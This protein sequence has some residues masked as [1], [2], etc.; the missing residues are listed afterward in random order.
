AGNADR[1]CGRIPDPGLGPR[2][3]IMTT[4][5]LRRF[6]LT[7]CLLAAAQ[8]WGQSELRFSLHTEPKTFH[9]LMVDD[10]ASEAVRYLT[11][12]VLLRLNRRT[13]QLE[14][15][16]ATHWKVSADGH[17]IS[18]TVREGVKFSDGTPFTAAD[19]VYTMKALMDPGLH[20]PLSDTFRSAPGQ[21]KTSLAAHNR[22]T[23][24]FPAT[25]AGL[26]KLFD[27]VAIMSA[28]SPQKERAV[29]GP[30]VVAKYKAGSYVEL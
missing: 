28:K 7:L 9:P 15:E 20:S 27:Q 24:T 13:Q 19:V 6:L 5:I 21:I 12:G 14:P 2:G 8:C 25:V 1:L 22:V 29:L 18:F 30:F 3:A 4:K 17:S 10:D 11:G 23:I 26:D 16:L